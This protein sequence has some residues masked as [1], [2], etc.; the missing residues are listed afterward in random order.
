[1]GVIA[2]GI[3]RG[4][5]PVSLGYPLSVFNKNST[6][7]Q[8]DVQVMDFGIPGYEY[9]V[10]DVSVVS[11]RDNVPVFSYTLNDDHLSRTSVIKRSNRTW[12]CFRLT[13]TIKRASFNTKNL[14][15]CSET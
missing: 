13:H 1:M 14:P 15:D 7:K 4:C 2:Q 5:P 8:G 10:W 11:N 9:L 6:L 3:P 12:F